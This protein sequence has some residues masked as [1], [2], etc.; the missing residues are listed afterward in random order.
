M[1]KNEF[2]TLPHTIQKNY[3]KM[4][5]RPKVKILKYL[6]ETHNLWLVKV[7]LEMMLMH[8]K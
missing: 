4:N 1:Q 7:F 5:Y 3:L 8:K 6:R 2:E